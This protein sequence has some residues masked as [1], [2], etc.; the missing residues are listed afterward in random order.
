METY[1]WVDLTTHR[2]REGPH[3]NQW[4]PHRKR[5]QYRKP[6]GGPLRK[7]GKGGAGAEALDDLEGEQADM[8]FEQL[9]HG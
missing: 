7:V 4:L 1:R 2:T 8:Q 9:M 5:H 3:R 6:K